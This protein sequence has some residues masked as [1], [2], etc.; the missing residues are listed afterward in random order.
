MIGRYSLAALPWTLTGWTPYLW[1]VQRALETGKSGG[2]DIPPI[3]APVPGS[4]QEALRAAGHLPD[5][6][7]GLQS[8]DCEWVEHRHWIY[9]VTLPDPWPAGGRRVRLRC[10]GLDGSGWIVVNG[11]EAGSF[12]D[13]FR[14]H[15]FDLTPFLR[16][17]GNTLRI[18]FD[19]PP[20]WLGQFG[21]TSTITE[22]KPRFNYTWDWMPRLVQIGIWDDIEL[23]VSDGTEIADLVC[24]ACLGA[25]GHG[26]LDIRANVREPEDAC[27][28]LTLI[29]GE[30]T[31]REGTY[32]AG[33]LQAGL[34]WEGLAVEAW[35][36]NGAGP[37]PL[38]TMRCRLLDR[39]GVGEDV[40]ERRAG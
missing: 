13:A 25:D 4:V 8:R 39:S 21:A 17:Q 34:R 18:V 9:A 27:V 26:A 12:S 20:R 38:Y 3:P 16:D 2:A 33:D 5:W 35:W 7:V 10:L 6:T 37:Q 1:R 22:W 30:H 36:P 28:Q 11:Q 23:E 14:P 24:T 15:E 32:P 40:V 19:L 29:R 31:I